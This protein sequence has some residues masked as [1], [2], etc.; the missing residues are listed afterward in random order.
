[1]IIVDNYEPERCCTDNCC[2]PGSWCC[3]RAN[4]HDHDEEGNIL[5]EEKKA[6]RLADGRD[7]IE[8][9]LEGR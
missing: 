5:A 4:P 1:V 9:F 7:A 2:G 3:A 8:D 6:K